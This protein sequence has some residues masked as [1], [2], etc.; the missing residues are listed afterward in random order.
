M[1]ADLIEGSCKVDD[2][3]LQKE[4]W[5]DKFNLNI[6]VGHYVRAQSGVEL[7]VESITHLPGFA[8]DI[9]VGLALPREA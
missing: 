2:A 7:K 1:R 9:E 6:A 4:K 3:A 8:T 5:P